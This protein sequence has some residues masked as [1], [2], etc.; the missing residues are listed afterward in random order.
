MP[1]PEVTH[2]IEATMDLAAETREAGEAQTI[3]FNL[4]GHGTPAPPESSWTS[5]SPSPAYRPVLQR[6]GYGVH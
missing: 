6:S 3:L 4:C 5:R 1:A 2:T